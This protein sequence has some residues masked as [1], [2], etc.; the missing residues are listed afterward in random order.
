MTYPILQCYRNALSNSTH[1]FMNSIYQRFVLVERVTDFQRMADVVNGVFKSVFMTVPKGG[2]SQSLHAS[3]C[4][5]PS[6]AMYL[7]YGLLT[8]FDFTHLPSRE[9]NLTNDIGF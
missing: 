2:A 7:C 1:V 3:F 4:I 9:G 8:S 6:I 5:Y